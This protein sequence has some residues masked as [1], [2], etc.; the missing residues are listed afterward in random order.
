MPCPAATLLSGPPDAG[1]SALCG[2]ILQ[3]RS[4]EGLLTEATSGGAVVTSRLDPSTFHVYCTAEGYVDCPV[5]R[6]E[7]QRIWEQRYLLSADGVG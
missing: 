2:V 3:D 6:A 5:W 7:R 4:R 1:P